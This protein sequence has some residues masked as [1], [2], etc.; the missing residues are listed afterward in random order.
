MKS[1]RAVAPHADPKSGD[2]RV[3]NLLPLLFRGRQGIDGFGRKLLAHTPQDKTTTFP[4]SGTIW[5][6]LE[7]FAEASRVLELCRN[8]PPL[9]IGPPLKQIPRFSFV[10]EW[11][12]G[13]AV[14]NVDG[15]RH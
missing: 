14:H 7:G 12:N 13:A 11:L 10:L 8:P 9:A 1:I 2:Q 3:T 4:V 6:R 15:S 5:K